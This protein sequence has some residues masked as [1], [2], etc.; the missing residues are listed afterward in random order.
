MLKKYSYDIKLKAVLDVINNGLSKN[1]VAKSIGASTTDIRKWVRMYEYHGPDGLNIQ[2]R[3]YS[4]DFKVYAVEYMYSNNLSSPEAA[5]RLGIPSKHPLSEWERIYN[6]FGPD[7]LRLGK[8]GRN[9][10]KMMKK[11]AP[12]KNLANLTE[13]ELILEVQR[14]QMEN[15]YL[16]KLNA[17]IQ[18][19]RELEQKTK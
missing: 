3:K 4:G 11:V 15:D 16:K 17:L 12:A 13:K 1:S 14:L 8:R 2:S 10:K 19:R 5:A 18:K 7:V 9:N 6:T